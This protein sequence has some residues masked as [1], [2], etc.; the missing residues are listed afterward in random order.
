[1][2]ASCRRVKSETR[3]AGHP[4]PGPIGHTQC[5][6]GINPTKGLTTRPPL[7]DQPLA[8]VSGISGRDLWCS[9]AALVS[10]AG[11]I[12][13]IPP[14]PSDGVALTQRRSLVRP[15]QFPRTGMRQQA[16][17]MSS[18]AAGTPA[19]RACGNYYAGAWASSARGRPQITMSKPTVSGSPGTRV[20][21]G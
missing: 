10:W 14:P 15:R 6:H 5:H 18:W 11:G 21:R 4:A 12:L 9:R 13:G 17:P 16:G 8:A 7:I 3:G 19:M 20:L 1:M 2:Q